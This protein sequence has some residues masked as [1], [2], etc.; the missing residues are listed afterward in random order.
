MKSLI[1]RDN[2]YYQLR[3]TVKI[4]EVAELRLHRDAKVARWGILRIFV[5]SF[6]LLCCSVS[7][8]TA[9]VMLHESSVVRGGLI[10]EMTVDSAA[11]SRQLA[12]DTLSSRELKR[13]ERSMNPTVGSV[14]GVIVDDKRRGFL[15]DSMSLSRMSWTSL[16]LPGYSQMYN[17]QYWKVPVLYGALAAG[18]TMYIHENNR[19][20]PLKAEFDALTYGDLFRTDEVNAV[21]NKMI[22]ANT[23]RQLVLG[24]TV[25]TYLYAMADGALNYST[26]D[27]SD[28]KRATTLAT[29][30]P[31]AGQIY[32]KSYWKVP[33]VIGGFASM[34]YVIDWNNRGYTRFKTAYA[35]RYDFDVNPDL[36]PGGTSVDEF[37][38]RY[39][40]DYL[41]SL[42]DSYRRN[43]DLSIIM[44]VGLYALQII[45][46]HVDAHFQD[47]D[48]SDDLKVKVAPQVSTQSGSLNDATVGVNMNVTF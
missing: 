25:A 3:D 18:V 46:A 29:I 12:R 36:Y 43:R 28:I 39:T 31:G 1:L 32:N 2:R 22:R 7:L 6:V 26:N 47:Y 23:S 33:F 30:F 4:V 27:V 34:I 19:Y 44:L 15:P 37:S 8:S 24:A 10:A 11:L 40:A 45:D 35:L 5:I 13:M 41:K 17:K 42:R 9:Q 14:N 38:G 16:V 21:Q 20:K 48:I